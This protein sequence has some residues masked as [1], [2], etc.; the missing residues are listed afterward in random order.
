MGE[1]LPRNIT[2]ETEDVD[3]LKDSSI[4]MLPSQEQATEYMDCFFDHLNATYRYL[5]RGKMKR[6]L[7]S[8]YRDDEKALRD[9]ASL[10][11]FLSVMGSG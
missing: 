2:R 7:E 4:L 8:V 3:D 6:I 5:P 11:L 1:V 9:D 10:A